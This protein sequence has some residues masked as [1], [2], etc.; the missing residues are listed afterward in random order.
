MTVFA[1]DPV[2]AASLSDRAVCLIPIYPLQNVD[3]FAVCPVFWLLD[4]AWWG[5][6][7]SGVPHQGFKDL[8]WPFNDLHWVQWVTL[9]RFCQTISF[10]CTTVAVQRAGPY[11]NRGFPTGLWTLSRLLIRAKVWNA[12]SHH[13]TRAIASSWA[14]SRGMSIQHICFAAGWSSQNNFAR[15]YKFYKLDFLTQ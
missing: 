4:F 8:H 12:L 15:F 10:S 7:D 9:A 6:S 5:R 3:C 1:S 14:W 13:S 11:Q 2:A